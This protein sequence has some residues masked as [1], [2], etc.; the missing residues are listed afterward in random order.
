MQQSEFHFPSLAELDAEYYEDTGEL[1]PDTNTQVLEEGTSINNDS[2]PDHPRYP[3][4][5]FHTYPILLGTSKSLSKLITEVIKSEDKL[6]FI[7]NLS[8]TRREWNLVQVDFEQTM[9]QNPNVFTDGK[10]LVKFLI[11]HPDDEHYTPVNKRFWTEYHSRQGNYQLHQKFH[12]I[13]PS[14]NTTKYCFDKGLLPY[15][16]WVFINHANVFLHG[17]FDF[18]TLNETKTRDRLSQSDLQV[19]SDTSAKYDNEP[20]I[21]ASANT[22]FYIDTAFHSR[23]ENL[24][25]SK[26]IDTYN[27]EAYLLFR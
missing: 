17:P 2:W 18:A 4:P 24:R 11:A 15:T 8:D 26:K 23:H 12:L 19:L 20:P 13:R 6:F 3:N 14:E 1:N 9:E 7:S 21:I 25:V 22:A 10:F 27:A 16:K 5:V